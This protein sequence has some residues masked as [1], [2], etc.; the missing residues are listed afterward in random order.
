M[1][2]AKTECIV[3]TNDETTI[4]CTLVTPWVAGNWMPEVRDD[5]GLIPLSGSVS[6]YNVPL[7]ISGVSPNSD[8]NLAGGDILTVTGENF[9]STLEG[10][11]L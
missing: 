1:T 2:L 9:P 8:L 4:I 6:K 10:F 11:N 5:K 7:V 3:S